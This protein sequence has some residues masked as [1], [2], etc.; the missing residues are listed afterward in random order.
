M[1][2]ST[3]LSFAASVLIS[4][5]YSSI[6]ERELCL[7]VAGIS[8]SARGFWA[9]A[10]ISMGLWNFLQPSCINYTRVEWR[11]GQRFE[12]GQQ[13]LWKEP[14]NQWRESQLWVPGPWTKA[15]RWCRHPGRISLTLLPFL[16]QFFKYYCA[17]TTSPPQ[18]GCQ[19]WAMCCAPQKADKYRQ[20]CHPF[21]LFFPLSASFPGWAWFHGPSQTFWKT[22]AV[23]RS[24][25]E[26]LFL[27]SICIASSL[28]EELGGGGRRRCGFF[29]PAREASRRTPPLLP[30]QPQQQ[31][32][33]G[34]SG[35]RR[36]SNFGKISPVG[37]RD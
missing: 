22:S 24:R 26:Y 15:E 31:E 33:P 34:I 27:V 23:A 17:L 19:V 29:V 4:C 18:Q 11:G 20:I 35:G 28:G 5:W 12:Q 32:Q 7:E 25:Q 6:G 21:P 1:A 2:K 30:P 36:L 8:I 14:G 10:Q 37:S 13:A 9:P 16:I 3:H